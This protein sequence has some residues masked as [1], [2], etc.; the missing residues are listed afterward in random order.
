MNKTSPCL[1]EDIMDQPETLMTAK[2]ARKFVSFMLDKEG[3]ELQQLAAKEINS[4][5][6]RGHYS[7][8]LSIPVRHIHRVKSWLEAKGYKIDCGHTQRDGDWF[9][10]SWGGTK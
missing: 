3:S 6:R 4:A 5:V 2:E 10:V 9:H 1:L 8:T 7:T